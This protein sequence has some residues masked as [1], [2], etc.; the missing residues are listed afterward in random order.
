MSYIENRWHLSTKPY[1]VQ[2]AALNLSNHKH[3]MH[4]LWKWDWVRLLYV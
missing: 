2:T 4:T 1:E 3:T